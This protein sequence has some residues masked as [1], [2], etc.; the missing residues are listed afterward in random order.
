MK[1]E[2]RSSAVRVVCHLDPCRGVVARRRAGK[3]RLAPLAGFDAIAVS[4][5][6]DLFC[7]PRRRLSS[8]RSQSDG[9]DA[10]EIVTEVRGG[11]ARDPPQELVSF[12]DWGG[13]GSVDVTLPALV[14]LTAS[15]GSDVR[16]EGTFSGDSCSSSS[17]PAAA[18]S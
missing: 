12:F 4:G 16:T 11:R 8:S 15:G 2:Y 3:R 5:G 9:D 10:D 17:R 13:D 14:S 6:I 1:T 7:P 18:I